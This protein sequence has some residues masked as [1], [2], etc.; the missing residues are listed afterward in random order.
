MTDDVVPLSEARRRARARRRHAA[1]ASEPEDDAVLC[2][3][4]PLGHRDGTF[5]FLTDCGELRA[6]RDQSMNERGLLGLMAGDTEWL[7][8]AAPVL[9]KEGNRT[10]GWSPKT[11][12]AMLMCM[13][14][15]RGLFDPAT[16]VR[17]P[18][19]WHGGAGS[20]IV[21][22]GDGLL[23]EGKWQPAGQ[24]IDSII[25][26]AA[27]AIGRPATTCAEKSAG[28]M[29]LK[30]F[31][32]W[33]FSSEL[34]PEILLGFVGA[35]MLGGAPAFRPHLLT[36]GQRG[37]GKTWLSELVAAALGGGAFQANE[38]TEAGL[39]Q[40]MTGEARCLVLDETENEEGLADRIAAVVQLLRRMTGGA[41]ARVL[42]GSA[43]G[44]AQVFTVTG[45]A[46][47]AAILPPVLKPQDRSRINIVRLMPLPIG[48]D[49]ADAATRARKAIAWAGEASPALRARAIEGW[50]RFQNTFAIYRAAFLGQGV[51]G[52]DADR[53]ATV[54]AGRDLLLHDDEPDSDS[55][56]IEVDRYLELVSEAAEQD[57][58][59]EGQQCLT[60][61]YSSPADLWRGGDRETVAEVIMMALTPSGSEAKRA[62]GKLGLALKKDKKSGSTVLLVANKNVT[63]ERFYRDTRW[64]EGRWQQA[65]RYLPGAYAW[66]RAAGFAGTQV[67]ATA[68]PEAWFPRDDA[69]APEDEGQA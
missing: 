56:Y 38:T 34:G 63:L 1:G 9:D 35:A 4:T 45:C 10:G 15:A 29:L 27:P 47:L 5:Y 18:G 22:A 52:R 40:L 2:P 58:E 6:I 28:E 23:I 39:R 46:Y 48:Q 8:W 43:G 19:V 64:A 13:C 36:I 61:L 49:Q 20:L 41:G 57:D 11:A 32:L 17:G 69:A 37:T 33:R 44:K 55:V 65:L 53:I 3:L 21:H 16:P 30:A 24:L 66:G 7:R 12:A 67:R 31:Q 51:D 59:G 60:Q 54:L 14:R 62:L 68:L 25:Y 50:Q 26:A 42:R